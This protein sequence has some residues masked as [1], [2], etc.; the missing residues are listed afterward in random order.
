MAI[1]G[2]NGVWT[3]FPGDVGTLVVPADFLLRIKEIIFSNYQTNDHRCEL[4]DG[5]GNIVFSQKGNDDL[6]DI[7]QPIACTSQ[8]AG[9]ELV[10]LDS[11]TCTV[12]VR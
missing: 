7:H 9:L 8:V 1:I 4:V 6:L 2:K 3:L 5:K 12:I 11:G 10:A